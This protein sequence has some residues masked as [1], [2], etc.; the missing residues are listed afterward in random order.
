LLPA[1]ASG[2]LGRRSSGLSRTHVFLNFLLA[3]AQ[4]RL[5]PKGRLILLEVWLKRVFIAKN[6]LTEAG[7]TRIY[8]RHYFTVQYFF[9]KHKLFSIARTIK[10]YFSYFILAIIYLTHLKFL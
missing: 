3:L 7:G 6:P 8:I 5:K 10:Q 4:M 2:R 1:S 9:M